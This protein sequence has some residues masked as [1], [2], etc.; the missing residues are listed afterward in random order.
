MHYY[1]CATGQIAQM[2]SQKA[3]KDGNVWVQIDGKCP[4]KK[5]Y[6]KFIKEFNSIGQIKYHPKD[7]DE[8]LE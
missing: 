5:D 1:N 6:E 2:N 4:E 3:D 8:N 7:V